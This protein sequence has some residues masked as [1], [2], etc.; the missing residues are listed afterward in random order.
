[1]CFFGVWDSYGLGLCLSVS[2]FPGLR[3]LCNPWQRHFTWKSMCRMPQELFPPI[4]TRKAGEGLGKLRGV[5]SSGLTS[6]NSLNV[7]DLEELE[8]Y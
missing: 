8:N 4:R 1:M 7:G 6:E 5:R 2:F 3:E